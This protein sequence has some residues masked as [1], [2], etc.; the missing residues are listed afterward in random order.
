[1]H[2]CP[3]CTKSYNTGYAGYDDVCDKHLLESY[4]DLVATVN[5]SK[6]DEG[7]IAEVESALDGVDPK[8]IT[9]VHTKHDGSQQVLKTPLVKILNEIIE[10][11]ER[12][13]L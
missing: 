4:N 6:T 11:K 3:A 8:S 1:M 2:D 9:I 10:E 13:G 7:K 5:A 12:R